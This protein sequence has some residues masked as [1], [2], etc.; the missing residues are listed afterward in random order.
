MKRMACP[1]T[2][3]DFDVLYAMVDRWRKAQTTRIAGLKTEA[4]KKAELCTLLQKELKLLESIEAH[5]IKAK[6]EKEKEKAKKVLL[7]AGKPV[8]WTGYNGVKVKM[9]TLRTQR[10]RELGQLYEVLGKNLNLK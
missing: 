4:A 10:A 3:E 8:E 5:R 7:H 1:K 2:K 9:D 6:E